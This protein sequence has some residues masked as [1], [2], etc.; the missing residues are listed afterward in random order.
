[1]EGVDSERGVSM[2][3]GALRHGAAL[4]GLTVHGRVSG[5]VGAVLEI[6]LSVPL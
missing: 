2:K 6:G 3:G 4:G 1:M 5:W